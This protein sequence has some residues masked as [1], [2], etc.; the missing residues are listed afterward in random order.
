MRTRLLL[1]LLLTLVLASCDSGAK[2]PGANAPVSPRVS[3][4]SPAPTATPSKDSWHITVTVLKTTCHGATGCDI[5]YQ[6]HPRFVGAGSAKSLVVTYE[7]LGAKDGPHHNTFTTD[8]EGNLLVKEQEV[9]TAATSATRLT[10][11]I[12]DVQPD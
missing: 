6:V 8:E 7:V 2:A 11:R 5:T 3:A 1:V 10:A 9:L 12:T 4:T